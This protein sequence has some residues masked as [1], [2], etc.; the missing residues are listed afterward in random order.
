MFVGAQRLEERKREQL[1]QHPEAATAAE[2]DG[3]EATHASVR[4][5]LVDSRRMQSVTQ[6][7]FIL[8]EATA[9]N[10]DALGEL[11][12]IKICL[13]SP[14]KLVGGRH[15]FQ[16]CVVACVCARC[17]PVGAHARALA[18]A[19]ARVRAQTRADDC[20]DNE[21]LPTAFIA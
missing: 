1:R 6:V 18:H 21:A 13:P 12:N 4:L 3:R 19:S 9:V 11:S 8:A 5:D 15:I 7:S 10:K 20:V 14:R 17:A 2:H 16:T